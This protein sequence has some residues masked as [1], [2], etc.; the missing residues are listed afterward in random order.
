VVSN[1]TEDELFKLKDDVNCWLRLE[2]A[3]KLTSQDKLWLMKDDKNFRVRELVRKRLV[4]DY[5]IAL[6][7]LNM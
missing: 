2:I 5:R 3:S 7:L 1:K 6:E 4:G